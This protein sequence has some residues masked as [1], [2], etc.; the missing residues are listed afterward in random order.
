MDPS[1]SGTARAA[2]AAVNDHTRT[3]LRGGAPLPPPSTI[4]EREPE[5]PLPPPGWYCTREPG[6]DGPC[7]ALPTESRERG[8]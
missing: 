1:L 6:H 7:A 4:P 3:K 2:I 5:C 8:T